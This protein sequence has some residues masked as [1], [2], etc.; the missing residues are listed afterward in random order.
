MDQSILD[1]AMHT[2]RRAAKAACEVHVR[3]AG[4]NFTVSSKSAAYDLVTS[5]DLESER[6]IIDIL[7]ADT[8][9]FAILSEEGGGHRNESDYLW[10]IDPLDGTN[11][12][13]KGI[14]FSS[15]SIALA[16]KKEV[17]GGV[18]QSIFMPECFEATQ[19]GGAFMN[20]KKITCS[21]HS[22]LESALLITG[23]FYDRGEIITRTLSTIGAFFDEKI[24]CI[25][26]FGSAAL[27][28]CYIAAGRA[29]GFW[30]YKLHPWDYAAAA[31][32]LREAGGI[33]SHPDGSPLG[34]ETGFVV[35]GCPGVYDPMIR[36]IRKNMLG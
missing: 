13:S 21:S 22:G 36:V 11:N 3:N 35:G 24:M 26:R 34:I 31:L 8:P 18:V 29:E 25:R 12:F 1:S 16:Y 23:F 32:I 6:L 33:T 5:S 2:A 7:K 4:T 9:D 10:I 14:P 20:G 28:L 19:G 30:E 17:I 27:D 15:V